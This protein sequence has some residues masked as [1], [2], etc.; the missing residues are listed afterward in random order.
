MIIRPGP[1]NLITDIPGLLVGNADDA[2]LRSGVTV[3]L[4]DQ[5]AVAAVCVQG[6]APG[7]RETDALRSGMLVDVIHGLVLSGGSAYGLDAGAGVMNWLARRGRG[8]QPGPPP[9]KPVPI[10]PAAILFDLGSGNKEW[11]DDPPYRRLGVEACQA[12]GSD[13]A[14]GSAG[15]GL[16]A[17]AGRIKGGLGSASAAAENGLIVGAL[18]A[19][20]PL[21]A[22]VMPGGRLWAADLEQGDEMGGQPLR[23]DDG[24]LPLSLPAEGRLGGHTTIAAVATNARLSRVELER[25]CLMAHDGMARAIRPVHSPFDGDTVFGL[26]AGD[27][28]SDSTPARRLGLIGHLAADCLTRAIGRAVVAATAIDEVPAYRDL[29]GHL[30]KQKN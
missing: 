26:S 12:A 28:T 8:Y 10:V 17:K 22:V 9:M 1:R 3:L 20:N 6:G 19:V 7:T 18:A 5:P 11:G 14:L 27:W 30:L 24:P 16:G 4:P 2:E 13:F 15:A 29:F 21:G 25:V 23:G